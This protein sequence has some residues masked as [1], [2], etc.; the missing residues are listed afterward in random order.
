[1]VFWQPVLFNKVFN[2]T[3]SHER[4]AGRQ[5]LALSVQDKSY[6]QRPALKERHGS[7][8]G[9]NGIGRYTSLLRY[10]KNKREWF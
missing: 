9:V 6:R 8:V 2:V 3:D 10:R 4:A 7:S 1:M 5:P